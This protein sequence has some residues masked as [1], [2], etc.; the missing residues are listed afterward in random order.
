MLNSTPWIYKQQTVDAVPDN[1]YGFIYKITNLI[2]GRMYIGRKYF[3][4]I[5]KVANKKKRVK[6]E[7]DWKDYYG[8]SKELLNDIEILGKECFKREILS[9]HETKGE[10]N[11]M[12]TYIQFKLDV[13]YAVN[14]DN[15]P[16]Y[17]N[18]NILSRY[19]A[20]ETINY[21]EVSNKMREY[22]N[23]LSDNEKFEKFKY[24]KGEEKS[25]Q[26]KEYWDNLSDDEKIKHLK[27]LKTEEANKKRS[28]ILIYHYKDI[29]E[30]TID[31]STKKDYNNLIKN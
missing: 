17:Y 5:R 31:I 4:S 2:D 12:E 10:V 19:F 25:I 6:K 7:S 11:F 30:N 29:C 20:P 15:I 27:P 18:K 21:T 23:N 9:F 26:S 16:L 24:F 13:L 3:W 22:W 8:S 14:E 1:K 28:D